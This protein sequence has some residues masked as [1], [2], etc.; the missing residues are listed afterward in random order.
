MMVVISTDTL[1]IIGKGTLNDELLIAW[2]QEG[3]NRRA[4]ER[5]WSQ[6][7]YIVH[8]QPIYSVVS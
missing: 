4:T 2:H 1:P 6:H 8:L 3:V 5:K 7:L